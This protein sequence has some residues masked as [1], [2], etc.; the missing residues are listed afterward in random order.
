MTPSDEMTPAHSVLKEA[1]HEARLLVSTPSLGTPED[2][3][4]LL[5]LAQ[6]ALEAGEGELPVA[7]VLAAPLHP[8]SLERLGLTV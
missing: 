3:R 6:A 5:G 7:Q 8:T 4:K 2:V 1:V